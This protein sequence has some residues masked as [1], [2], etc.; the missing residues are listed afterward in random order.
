MSER[1]PRFVLAAVG[2]WV[3]LTP[4][5]A[6]AQIPI[7]RPATSPFYQPPISPYPNL[8]RGG[9]PAINYYGLVR[10]QQT[11]T[12]SLQQLQQQQLGT[13][14]PLVTAETNAALPV[15]G[16]LTQFMNFGPFYSG[17]LVG[18]ATLKPVTVPT[19]NL[20]IASPPVAPLGGGGLGVRR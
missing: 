7:G 19:A 2:F 11:F 8:F 4:R 10:P 17:R 3:L 1:V 6:A 14:A 18:S 16:H 13:Q 5:P 9:N 12:N 20:P 15:T